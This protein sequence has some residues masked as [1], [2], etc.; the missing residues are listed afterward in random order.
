M[1]YIKYNKK[2]CIFDKETVIECNTY[3]III[4]T[5]EI[6]LNISVTIN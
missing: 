6:L 3:T 1:Y 4:C 5:F 2:K